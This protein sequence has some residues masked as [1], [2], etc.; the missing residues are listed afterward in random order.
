[1]PDGHMEGDA[2]DYGYYFAGDIYKLDGRRL[3][4]RPAV[5]AYLKMNAWDWKGAE[6]ETRRAIDLNPNL[7]SAHGAYAEY[8]SLVGRHDEAVAEAKRARELD[9]LYLRIHRN[10]GATFLNARRYEEAIE[11]LGKALELDP[12]YDG[13]HVYLGYTYAAMGKYREALAEYEVVRRDSVF[14]PS[15]Q[16]YLGAAYA[17][18]GEVAKARAVLKRLQESGKY[19]SPAEIAILFVALGEREEAF[20]SL[21]KAYA[22]H[23]LQLKYLKTEEGYDPIRTD[24][25]FVDLMRRVGLPQ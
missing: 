24:P 1:M 18:A 16:I 20:A 25:R 11:A 12:K 22:E 17:G 19:Y 10:L 3:I 4:N 9:P 21:E 23:D 6:Q 2:V 14:S 13:A 7:G 15:T 5:R 8:L